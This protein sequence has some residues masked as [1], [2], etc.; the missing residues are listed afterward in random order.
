[1]FFPFTQCSHR[2]CARSWRRRWT[3]DLLLGRSVFGLSDFATL[4]VF[5]F[6]HPPL[7]ETNDCLFL[8]LP[9]Y[10][11]SPQVW[12]LLL[13]NVEFLSNSGHTI[14]HVPGKVRRINLDYISWVQLL[15][16]ATA[17]RIQPCRSRLWPAMQESWMIEDNLFSRHHSERNHHLLSQ[18]GTPL[19]DKLI[20][21]CSFR[22]S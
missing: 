19:S 15:P 18:A 10:I 17:F 6:T 21:R 4:W 22:I 12:Q 1:M 20:I 5:P 2:Q 16:G 8:N 9:N 3:A 11:G 14:A 7:Q 13:K